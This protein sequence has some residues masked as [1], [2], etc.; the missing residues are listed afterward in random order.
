MLALVALSTVVVLQGAATAPRTGTAADV[1][2]A[3]PSD[4]ITVATESARY[5]T[6]MAW[7]PGGSRR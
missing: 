6:I 4:G 2:E 3:P 7:S 5:G 1:P